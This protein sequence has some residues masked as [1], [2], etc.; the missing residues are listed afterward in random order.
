MA[1][2]D[3]VSPAEAPAGSRPRPK[4]GYLVPGIIALGVCAALGVI[5]DVAGLQSHTAS[6]LAG[7]DVE[8][9]VSQSL[10]A[11]TGQHSPPQVRCPAEEPRRA[12]VT[13]DCT[14]LRAGRP[15]AVI[16]V[17]ETSSS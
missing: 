10:Q 9:L 17:T 3:Y 4:R 8:V 5:I 1:E 12:G 13:F 16:T 7:A 6:H 14:L 11:A 2:A 15:P